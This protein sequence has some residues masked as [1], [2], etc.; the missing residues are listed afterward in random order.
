MPT[1]PGEGLGEAAG[2]DGA[3]TRAADAAGSGVDG[4][5]VGDLSAAA[6]TGQ[7]DD[8]QD[9]GGARPNADEADG[10]EQG[11]RSARHDVAAG[12]LTAPGDTTGADGSAP[13]IPQPGEQSTNPAGDALP[14]MPPDTGISGAGSGTGPAEGEPETSPPHSGSQPGA[15][16][17]SGSGAGARGAS[18]VADVPIVPL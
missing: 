3:N 14:G 17:E 2:G 8:Q 10:V 9:S 16:G 5:K 15:A 4:G 1:T 12:E 18:A 11:L 6:G 13:L 7:G